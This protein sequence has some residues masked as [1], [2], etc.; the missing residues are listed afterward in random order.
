MGGYR[1]GDV[2]A[3]EIEEGLEALAF[4][5]VLGEGG[6]LEAEVGDLLAE[7]LIFVTDVAEVEIVGPEVADAVAGGGAGALEGAEEAE[8]PEAEE[9]DLWG[10]GIMGVCGAADLDGE[11]DGLREEDRDEDQSVFE[12]G[13]EGF[14]WGAWARGRSPPIIRVCAD[15]FEGSG[16][17]G[18]DEWGA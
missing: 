9:T 1:L 11:R 10:V 8:G 14:H 16:A 6:A 15:G 2:V 12:A 4:E 17:N 18:G 13:E 7:V 3:A 5:G